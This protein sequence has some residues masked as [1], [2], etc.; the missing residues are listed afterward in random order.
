MISQ[1]TL[2]FE[3]KLVFSMP[4]RKWRD[5]FEKVVYKKRRLWGV[6]GILYYEQIKALGRK[7]HKLHVFGFC[8]PM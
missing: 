8:L 3:E 4:D 6:G 1:R 5:I 7:W 2:E